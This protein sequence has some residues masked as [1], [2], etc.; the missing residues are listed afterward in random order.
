[1]PYL[2]RLIG[3]GLH[4]RRLFGRLARA[5]TKN[6]SV[7]ITKS[8]ITVLLH[9]GQ[10]LRIAIALNNRR[11]VRS[12]LKKSNGLDALLNSTRQQVL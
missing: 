1:M 11:P 9:Q 10:H 4:T 2:I 8:N 12:K 3:L 6:V 7:K 5:L